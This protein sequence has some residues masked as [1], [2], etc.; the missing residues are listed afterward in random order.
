MDAVDL[1]AFSDLARARRTSLLV[2][3]ARSVDPALIDRLIELAT[4]APNHKKTWPWRFAV[5]TGEGR[6]RLGEAFAADLVAGGATDEARLAKTTGKY[7]RSP[8]V[9]V[10]A[11][12]AHP[13]AE[14]HEENRDAASAA[15]QNVLLGATAAGLASFWSSPPTRVSPTAHSLCGFPADSQIVALVYLG[16]PSPAL[17]AVP[18]RPAPVVSYV[19]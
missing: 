10:V 18:A 5:C 2:D 3:P 6:G 7:R 4:W 12:D 9:V 14:L 16:W 19:H 13:V 17:V 15:V 11:S 8:V 1:D